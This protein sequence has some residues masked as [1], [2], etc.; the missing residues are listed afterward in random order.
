MQITLTTAWGEVISLPEALAID[1]EDLRMYEAPSM[2]IPNRHGRL[3]VGKRP[4]R[5]QRTIRLSG[6]VRDVDRATLEATVSE[7]NGKLCR[8]DLQLRRDTASDRY[9][10]VRTTGIQ[11]NPN[12]GHFGGRVA[13]ISCTLVADDPFWHTAEQT[14][15]HLV[16]GT[17]GQIVRVEAEA[18]GAH[19]VV[20]GNTMAAENG[21][22]PVSNASTSGGAA[23]RTA[24]VN[25]YYDIAFYG[26]GIS[27]IGTKFAQ[28]GVGEVSVDG[29]VHGTFDQFA[30]NAVYQQVLYSAVGLVPGQHVCRIGMT[31]TKNPSSGGT[32]ISLDA[33]DIIGSSVL[34]IDNPGTAEADPEI[35]IQAVEQET[36]ADFLGKTAGSVAAN[37]HI[38]KAADAPALPA[39][40]DGA[41]AEVN[42]AGYDAM[43]KRGGSSHS[44]TTSVATRYPGILVSKNLSHICGGNVDLVRANLTAMDIEALL[45]AVGMNGSAKDWQ[46]ELLLFNRNTSQWDSQGYAGMQFSRASTAYR[47][48]DGAQVAA[49]V[50]RFELGYFHNLLTA[51]QSSVETDLTGIVP[52]GS[53][54]TVEP[55][56]V[57]L[58]RDT[59][60]HYDGAAAAKVVTDGSKAYQGLAAP[61]LTARLY[62]S[63]STVY[64]VRARVKGTAG[65][66]IIIQGIGDAAN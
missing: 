60:E 46:S 38:A 11:V 41:W 58:T 65:T 2:Q 5:D 56:G 9:L 12:R 62:V 31:G 45:D 18:P 34:T 42:Q 61:S 52:I 26:V 15:E 55:T 36:S 49:N 10:W 43:A 29:V 66:N 13:T 8:D 24:T 47:L 32:E 19:R 22:V 14:I 16:S 39:P 27:I 23:F 40:S 17:P 48:R 57:T 1:D 54:S 37:K 28:A 51:N 7:I 6:V 50:P 30:A 25:D 33:F 4:L 63:P 35:Y 20:L 53:G 64:A 21:W 59:T 3:V 44:K